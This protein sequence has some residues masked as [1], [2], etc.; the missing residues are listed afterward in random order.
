LKVCSSSPEVLYFLHERV[1]FLHVSFL[2]SP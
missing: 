1:Y 2:N